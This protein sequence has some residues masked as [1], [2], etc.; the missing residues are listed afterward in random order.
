MTDITFDVVDLGSDPTASGEP[1]EV[2]VVVGALGGAKCVLVDHGVTTPPAG[3]P[4]GSLIF[5]KAT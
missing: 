3:T 1:T 2:T 4:V 5:Q